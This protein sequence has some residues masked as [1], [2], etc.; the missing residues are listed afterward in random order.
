MQ[1]QKKIA[2]TERGPVEYSD[3]GEGEVIL[4][5]HGTGITCDG[6]MPIE[7]RLIAHRFRLTMPNRRATETHRS[8]V[9]QQQLA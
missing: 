3:V 5:F 7:S 2:Q 4:Y 8:F 9:G 1:S 6:M